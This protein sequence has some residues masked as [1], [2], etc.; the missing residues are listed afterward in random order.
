MDRYLV[1]CFDTLRHLSLM[2][3]T[4]WLGYLYRQSAGCMGSIWSTLHHW[5]V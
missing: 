4:G 1:S 2:Y 3:L 5:E